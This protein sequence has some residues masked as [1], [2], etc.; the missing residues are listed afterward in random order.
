MKNEKHMKGNPQK[1]NQKKSINESGTVY[2]YFDLALA[3]NSV[4]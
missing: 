3:L 1:Q 2:Y 4:H